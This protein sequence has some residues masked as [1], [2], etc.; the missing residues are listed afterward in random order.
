MGHPADRRLPGPARA[1]REA[2]RH[3]HG[4]RLQGRAHVPASRAATGR[5]LHLS[6]MRNRRT[7]RDGCGRL[8]RGVHRLQLHRAAVH[9]CGPAAAGPLAA[10]PRARAGHEPVGRVQYGRQLRDQHQLA[11]L[12]PRDVG[13]LSHADAR[14][15]ARE[16]RLGR[17]RHGRGGGLHPR[18]H[19][20]L[21]A[22]ARQL[23]GRFHAQLP[24]HPAAHRHRRVPLP[25]LAG[26]RAEPQRPHSRG[27]G[28]GRDADD[29][30]RS[31]RLAGDHQGAGHQRRRV[32]QRQLRPSVREPDATHQPRGDAGACSPSP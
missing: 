25:R 13:E 29:R 19:P 5:T 18:P 12:H 8:R 14:A 3:V 20:P 28:A 24:L 2:P 4:A 11:G 23:L 10:Q 30:A 26:R 31:V 22:R 7:P 17:D 9:V 15:R 21:H 6:R 16:L 27:D 32:L 1:D